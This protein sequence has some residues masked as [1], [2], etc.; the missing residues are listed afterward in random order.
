MTLLRGTV[1]S[2]EYNIIDNNNTYLTMESIQIK[3][4]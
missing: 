2:S 3:K 1:L 4:K